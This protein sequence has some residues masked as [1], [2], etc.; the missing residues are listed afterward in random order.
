MVNQKWECPYPEFGG[1]D[2]CIFHIHP[3]TREMTFESQEQIRLEQIKAV[4]SVGFVQIIC[5]ALRSIN[6]SLLSKATFENTEIQIGYSTIYE[7]VNA[8]DSV[9]DNYIALEDCRIG[10][11]KS[12]SSIYNSGLR[13]GRS[14]INSLELSESEINGKATFVGTNLREAKF[15]DTCFNNTLSFCETIPDRTPLTDANDHLGEQPCEFEDTPLFMGTEFN[16][17]A[18]FNEV[19][20]NSGANFHHSQFSSGC[21]FEDAKINIGCHF[22]FAEFNEETVFV[23]A[24]LGA[25]NF[26]KTKFHGPVIFNNASFGTGRTYSKANNIANHA[27]AEGISPDRLDHI[28]NLLDDFVFD[29][30]IVSVA[31][32]AASFDNT[33]TEDLFSAR[34]VDS[35]GMITAFSSH[36]YFMDLNLEFKSSSP[37]ISFHGS[38]IEGGIIRISDQESFY[39]WANTTVGDISIRSTIDRNAFKNILIENTRFEGFD[40]SD[41]RKELR[42][43]DWNIDG[44][45][46]DNEHVHSDRR[47]AT[48]AKA[49]SGA[50][51][52]GDHYAE[53]K[54]F[55]K[56]QQCRRRNHKKNIYDTQAA[57]D[58]ISNFIKYSSNL[59]YDISCKYAE[60]PKRVVYWSFALIVLFALIYQELGVSLPYEVSTPWISINSLIDHPHLRKTEISGLEYLIFS[61]ESFTSFIAG[62]SLKIKSPLI[63]LIISVQAFSGSF[64]IALFVATIIRTVKR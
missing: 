9:F 2:Y 30:G 7:N 38:E 1:L 39:E 13:I 54:F 4:R 40:F 57:K 5:S 46:H 55:I 18:I 11:L 28:S 8:S 59:F 32:K 53:S 51:Q 36:F 64:L 29:D 15:I 41:Y 16:G 22:G 24:E 62:S 33:Q 49:K 56:E 42:D 19:K 10:Q 21:S 34:N 20:F 37:T 35:Q 12:N 6:I 23:E 44:Y 31:G 63:R 45:F 58:I 17:G 43:I 3:L 52:V 50:E 26:E 60:S 47:E 61:L 25:A 27:E 48:Y 14:S